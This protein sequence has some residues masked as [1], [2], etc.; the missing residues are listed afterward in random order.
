VVVCRRLGA[1]A[2]ALFFLALCASLLWPGLS[3][4]RVVHIFKGSFGGEGTAPG[5]FEGP[6]GVAVNDETGD[7]YVVDRGG[8]RVEEFD[9]T[10]ST[11]IKEFNGT[12]SP[13]PPTGEFLQPTNITVD[14]SGSPLD[15]SKG[16]VYV[17]DSGHGVIDKFSA[18]GEYL[19]QL[20]GFGKGEFEATSVEGLAVDSL[21][22][23]WIVEQEGYI[24]DYTNELTNK[25]VQKV[26]TEFGSGLQNGLAV[27]AEGNIYITTGLIV[28]VNGNGLTV[29]NP[30][31]G[32]EAAFGVAVDPIARDVYVLN[33]GSVGV[34]ECALE[35]LLVESFGAGDFKLSHGIA[36]AGDGSVY[37]T[38]VTSD[39][40]AVFATVKLPTV[41]VEPLSGQ[42]PRSVILNGT[43]NPEG[44]EVTSCVFEYDTRP[45]DSEG[46]AA[47]GASVPCSRASLGSGTAPLAVVA[48]LGGLVPGACYFYRLSAENAA[49]VPSRT[50]GVEFCTGPRLGGE[51]VTDVASSGSLAPSSSA[52]LH[53]PID[54]NGDDTHY[55]IEYG[56]TASY[57]AYAPVPPPGVDL[58]SAV[59]ALSISV[60]LQGLQPGT[61]YHY[62][63]VAEQ[64]GELFEELDGTF[65][66]PVLAALGES[67]LPDGR[68]WELVSPVDKKGA[69]IEP[70]D[71]PDQ[72]QAASDG[73]GITYL[74]EGPHVGE[75]PQGKITWSQ[76]LSRR[77]PSG[78]SSQDLTLPMVLPEDGESATQLTT[79]APEYRLFSPGLSLAAVEPQDFGTPLLSPQA[80]MRTLYLRNNDTGGFVPLVTSAD[81][82]EPIEI[83]S[84][85][86]G[87]SPR[88]LWDMHFLAATPD[89]G[90]VV[91]KTPLALV[92]P[93]T[94]EETPQNTPIGEPQWNL[95]EWSG[96]GLGLINILPNGEPTSG[97]LPVTG[98]GATPLIVSLAGEYTGEGHAFGGAPRAVSS[99]GRRIAWTWGDTYGGR[100]GPSYKGLFVRDMVEGETVKVGGAQAV[101]QTMSSDGSRI[102]YT[103]NGDLYEYNY[104][105]RLQTDLTAKHGVG[106]TSGGVLPLVSDV[107][108]DGTDVY[109]V[110]NGVL[111]S[112]AAEGDCKDSE[113]SAGAVCNLYMVHY[114][115]G[116][117]EAPRLVAVLSG[118]DEKDWF[119]RTGNGSPE[120]GL[121][122]SKVSS[123]GRFLVFM[124]DRSLTGYDNVDVSS[125]V[126]EQRRDEEV[127]LYDAAANGGSGGLRCV[128]CNPTGA[129][130]TGVLDTPQS[131]LLVD[132]S[133]SWSVNNIGGVDHWLAGSVP[134]WDLGFTGSSYQPRYLFDDGRVFF[135][136][137]DSLV[138]QATN[139]LE[140]VYE[141]EPPGVGSCTETSVTFSER[142][143]GCVGLVSSGTSGAESAFLDASETGDDAFFVTLAKLA[144]R[145]IDN[146]YDVYDAHVCSAAVPCVP[147]TGGPPPCDSGDS[148]KAAPSPQ[149][150][151]FGPAPSATFN[152]VGNVSPS[153]PSSGVA[154]KKAT[155]KKCPRGRKLSR[156]KCVKTKA[157]HGGKATHRSKVGRGRKS[158]RG[159]GR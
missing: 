133:Y 121:V 68:M 11:L 13:V 145:D 154:G 59:G 79:V 55:Y 150:A 22:G 139:G 76:V 159:R 137:P 88:K 153:S 152:G 60:H 70:L 63:F 157:S 117:W 81:A 14:N 140:D 66:T 58:G 36:V 64:A 7:V 39:L 96:E 20:N 99:D 141:Y 54:P 149:P 132:R 92:S 113:P 46:E 37:V 134:G 127:Y 131:S 2:A 143:G 124:S 18:S 156:G 31:C 23:L 122:D 40:V 142:S 147:E 126:G 105:S 9:S 93:A 155:K 10:G 130:P 114:G 69:V 94:D 48:H 77:G 27:D 47:H 17:M 103:E 82:N 16:D 136:S 80:T 19:G 109:F 100:G 144:L 74:T 158:D 65:T 108:E 21:G 128:S 29:A 73:S 71:Q 107:S 4:A 123:D 35:N 44:E 12:G 101:F 138:P 15:P 85:A 5:E 87:S 75:N 97:P 119:A 3:Q 106:E 8:N 90:H 50:Q 89:L 125:P 83:E 49:G 112:G 28:E 95:Y 104:G 120:L 1:V 33:Q 57:G 84:F 86:G 78:W 72:I 102:F 43:V 151:I 148:C 129:R 62:R 26:L 52:T 6:I 30:I 24:Y 118:E 115:G 98:T 38:D 45:Y 42:T 25:L 110:A 111:A 61:V 135:D 91:F 53:A 32:A 56:T 67:A 41:A 146:S 116:E 34:K 51:F